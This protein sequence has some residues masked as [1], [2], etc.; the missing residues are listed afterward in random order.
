LFAENLYFDFATRYVQ[1]HATIPAPA[2]FVLSDIDFEAFKQFIVEK[3]FKYTT[4]TEKY[5]NDLLEI[6]KLEG[7]DKSTSEEFAALK[8]KLIPDITKSIDENKADITELLSL[9]IIKR[10]YFQ[11]G[12]IQ[13]SLRTDEDLKTALEVLKP[14]G[15]YVKILSEK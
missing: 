8:A 2:D 4:Q 10:Y 13:F 6:A 3:K 5:F 7:L 15:E 1:Q 9:E 11:K 14:E 12:E